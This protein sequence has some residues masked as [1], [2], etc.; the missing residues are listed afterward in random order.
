MLDELV[1]KEMET[2]KKFDG[3][4]GSGTGVKRTGKDW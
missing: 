4:K 2:K 3:V 1:K